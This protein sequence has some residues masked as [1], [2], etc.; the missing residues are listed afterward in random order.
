MRQFPYALLRRNQFWTRGPLYVQKTTLYRNVK[1]GHVMAF[2]M[3]LNR[4]IVF[5]D[6]RRPSVKPAYEPALNTLC[7]VK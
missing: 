4:L 6:I 7:G 3:L 2:D 5:H 1:V